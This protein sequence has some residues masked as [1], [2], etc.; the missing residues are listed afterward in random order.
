[1]LS[2]GEREGAPGGLYSLEIKSNSTSRN[3]M[4]Y[5][6]TFQDRVDATN[7]CYVLDPYFD[8][9]NDVSAEI[10]PLTIQVC[11][12]FYLPSKKK[13]IVGVRLILFEARGLYNI[14][15]Y[16]IVFPLFSS[17]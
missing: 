17:S 7:F 10:I 6:I 9:L 11:V 5:V 13:L 8:D 1:L 4:S 12:F 2:G 15:Q 14:I 16:Q 3:P